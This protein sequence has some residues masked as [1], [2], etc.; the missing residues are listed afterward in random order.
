MKRAKTAA[1]KTAIPKTLM[2]SASIRHIKQLTPDA[3]NYR[4]HNSKNIGLI[5]D[6]LHAV[7]AARSIVIDETGRILAGNATIEAAAQAGITAVRVIDTNGAEIVAV[8]RTGLSEKQK[9]TLAVADNKTA[10][11]A[12]GWMSELLAEDFTSLEL[13]DLGFTADDL[14]L[15]A[16]VG[17]DEP[18]AGVC[19]CPTCGKQHKKGDG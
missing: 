5:A 8:R 11:E 9:R 1:P 18:D 13:S 12:D 10:E 15:P 2:S 19:V 17:E 7:G 16:A 14:E 6:S 4:R 3:R